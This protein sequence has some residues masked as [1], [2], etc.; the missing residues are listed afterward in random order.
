MMIIL[1]IMIINN[2]LSGVIVVVVNSAS[3]S[4]EM[5]SNPNMNAYIFESLSLNLKSQYQKN[6]Y[7]NTLVIS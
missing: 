6:Q 3:C 1:S 2:L 5:N 7:F 4:A